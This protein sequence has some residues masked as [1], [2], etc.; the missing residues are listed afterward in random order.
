MK[1]F[2]MAGVQDTLSSK[3]ALKKKEQESIALSEMLKDKEKEQA[4]KDI[5][6][7]HQLYHHSTKRFKQSQE[8]KL[9]TQQALEAMIMAKQTNASK[10]KIPQ[11]IFNIDN[12]LMFEF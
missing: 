7:E 5:L 8:T 1:A 4:L 2:G 9:I 11:V 10:A 3:A 12:L 6:S